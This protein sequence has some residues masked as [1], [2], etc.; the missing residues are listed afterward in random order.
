[1]ENMVYFLAELG[2]MHYSVI[3]MYTPSIIAASAVYAAR[4]TLNKCPFWTETLN[5]YTGYSEVQLR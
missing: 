4:Y 2:L 3:V 5:H 1:M